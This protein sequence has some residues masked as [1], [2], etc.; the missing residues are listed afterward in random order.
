[1]RSFL[2]PIGPSLPL[3][4]SGWVLSGWT[5]RHCPHSL[6]N[7]TFR[8]NQAAPWAGW[9]DYYNRMLNTTN[10]TFSNSPSALAGS[11]SA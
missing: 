6:F 10:T 9:Q 8:N 3:T 7:E 4:L 11:P 2:H 5:Y 1:M